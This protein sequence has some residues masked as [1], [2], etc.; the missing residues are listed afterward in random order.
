MILTQ[1]LLEEVKNFVLRNE[2]MQVGSIADERESAAQNALGRIVPLAVSSLIE[3]A[4]QASGREVVWSM[5]H[6][7]AK[8]ELLSNP[9]KTLYATKSIS[10][11]GAKLISSLLGERYDSAVQS[12]ASATDIQPASVTNLLNIV[13]P[14]ALGL[15]GEQ[16]SEHN[17]NAESLSQWLRTQ[18]GQHTS[19]SGVPTLVM[20]AA[21]FKTPTHSQQR[22]TH[23]AEKTSRWLW[24]AL[25]VASCVIG[26][27]LGYQPTQE[28][29]PQAGNLASRAAGGTAA[30]GP[31]DAVNPAA[32]AANGNYSTANG[33]YIYGQ[34]GVP[35]VL[36]LKGGLR[37]IIG[38]NSTEN[39][40]Y[41][42]LA[43]PAA[44]VDTL[45]SGNDWIT[46]DRIYFEPNKAILTPESMWQLSNVASILNTFPQAHVQLGGYTDST[47][48]F[49]LNEKLSAARAQAAKATLVKMGVEAASVKAKGYGSR[50][51]IASNTTEDGRALNRRVSIRVT[52]K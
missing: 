21:T 51:N 41:Q 36:K 15:L 40:L 35:A 24:I 45:S 37:Q 38:V 9:H 26:Y 4:E 28:S 32:I 18:Q 2:L 7:A 16:A 19:P 39:K 52:K 30:D 20:P 47:G 50:H 25:V 46:F 23:S 27:L 6:E 14:V 34:A 44:Q 22:T 49:V 48:G 31:W 43:N 3:L 1:S 29:Y 5:A 33:S 17:W 13:V 11:R 10:S 8:S 42:F 12:I